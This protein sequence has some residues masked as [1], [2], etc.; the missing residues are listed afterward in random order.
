[1]DRAWRRVRI[2][3]LLDIVNIDGLGGVSISVSS[4]LSCLIVGMR[5]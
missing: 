2:F 4:L 5:P 3:L 1:M